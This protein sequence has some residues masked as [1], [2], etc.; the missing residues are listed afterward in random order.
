MHP[1]SPEEVEHLARGH[2]ALVART[3]QLPDVMNRPQLSWTGMALC[4]P[5]DGTGA[6]PLLRHAILNDQK[7]ATYKLGL[8]RAL[9]RAADGQAGLADKRDEGAVFVFIST[10][11]AG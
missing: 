2:G 8:L 1:V 11:R 4:L 9:C 5:D 7:T 6:L 3:V 10:L